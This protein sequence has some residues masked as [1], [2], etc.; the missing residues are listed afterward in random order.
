MVEKQ[1]VIESDD[2][3]SVAFH[4]V[5][6]FTP[7]HFSHRFD[8]ANQSSSITLGRPR[9]SFNIGKI[10]AVDR[11]FSGLVNQ[12]CVWVTIMLNSI[13]NSNLN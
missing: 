5:S 4:T 11:V 12:L 13:L 3:Q 8:A 2:N 7:F 9:N 6:L 10:H 1:V